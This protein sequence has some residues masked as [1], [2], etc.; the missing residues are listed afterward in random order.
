MLSELFEK[1]FSRSND[2]TSRNTAKDRLRLVIAHDR[3]DLTPE[4][5][6]SL[7]KEIVE[8]VS[9]YVEVDAEGLEFSLQSDRRTTALTANMPI[10]RIKPKSE[11]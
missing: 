7:Q 8:V 2:Q 11:E 5:L 1:L 6:D 4:M 10:R 3:C 9:R